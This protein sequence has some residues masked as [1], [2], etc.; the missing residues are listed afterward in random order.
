MAQIVAVTIDQR[1][2]QWV[3]ELTFGDAP[4][5]VTLL[6]AGD[7]WLATADEL[8]VI[9]RKTSTDLLNT[10]AQGRLLDQ[11][12]RLR[13]V[14]PWAYLVI[15]GELRPGPDGRTLNARGAVGWSWHSVQGAL[16]SAQELGVQV[17]HLADD[18][19]FLPGLLWLAG[20]ARNAQAVIEPTKTATWLNAQEQILCSLP[21]IGTEKA[22]NLLAYCGNAAW[23]LAY[24]T[25]M[26]DDDGHVAGI[27]DVIRQ[28]ARAALGLPNWAEL[29]LISTEGK[30]IEQGKLPFPQQRARSQSPY[31][32]D[33]LGYRAGD[34]RLPAVRCRLEGA[35]GRDHAQ[36]L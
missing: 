11:C 15:T 33:D 36:G 12:A 2:P 27:G 5:I 25:N 3:Q 34:A 28:K 4:T 29:A 35:G 20:R 6:D 16:L 10:I 13:A 7:V 19:A 9:E 21:E 18:A 24:L 31:L 23:A 30:L 22:R 8:V 14:S 1:E 32:A 26:T 17:V